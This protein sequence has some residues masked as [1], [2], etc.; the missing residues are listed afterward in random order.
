M[1]RQKGYEERRKADI[2]KNL[3][4]RK[5]GIPLLRIRFDQA[6]LI[7]DMINDF[8][9]NNEKYYQQFNTYLTDDSYYSLC[10]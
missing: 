10:K 2:E 6:Y 5:N 9:K 4:C 1:E 8:L 3:Y 7:P